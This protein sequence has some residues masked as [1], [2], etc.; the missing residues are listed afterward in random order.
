MNV[1]DDDRPGLSSSHLHVVCGSTAVCRCYLVSHTSPYL[2]VAVIVQSCHN[3]SNTKVGT[4]VHCTIDCTI[5]ATRW[6]GLVCETRC[7]LEYV[8][9]LTQSS[10]SIEY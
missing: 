2:C 8:T 3:N 4:G 5:I 10:N 6:L 1:N 9:S 7:F